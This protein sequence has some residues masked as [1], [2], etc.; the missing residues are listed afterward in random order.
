MIAA[1]VKPA[2]D[3]AAALANL[4]QVEP[5]AVSGESA[6]ELANGCVL[7]DVLEGGQPVGAVAVQI[8]GEGAVITAFASHGQATYHEL[9]LIE[10]ALKRSGVRR[11]AMLTRRPGL[12]RN[13]VREGYS[14]QR[15][16]LEKAL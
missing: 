3:P 14:L 9:A 8:E 15:A 11:V 1:A 13:L 10:A 12:V 6:Q 2:A 7:L 16:E 5:H 4:R